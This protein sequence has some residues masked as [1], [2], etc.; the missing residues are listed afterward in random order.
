MRVRLP[1]ARPSFGDVDRYGRG[2]ACRAVVLWAGVVRFHQS[3]SVRVMMHATVHTAETRRR[4]Y[5]KMVA[6]RI[7]WLKERGP[8]VDC[9]RTDSLQV[10]H[11]DRRL[12]VDH[13]VWSW[14]AD[15]RARELSKCVVRCVVCH[16]RKSAMEQYG[17]REHGTER[18][19][20]YG[21]CR[22][23]PCRDAHAARKRA[24]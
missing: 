20:H 18:M 13:K 22:C 17:P 8:C 6:R 19:Y 11:I 15:R 12:K 2:S 10:D 21:S 5:H 14:S 3:P 23:Q 7:A 1:P 16:R 24:S 4:A 9:G